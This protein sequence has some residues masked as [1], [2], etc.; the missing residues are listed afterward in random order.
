MQEEVREMYLKVIAATIENARVE[1]TDNGTEEATLAHLA[2][3]KSRWTER[4][5]ATQDFTEDPLLVRGA[6]AAAAS[7]TR[8]R[9][10]ADGEPAKKRA[11]KEED[12]EENPDG[13]DLKSDLGS[14]SDESDGSDPDVDN[15]VL[16]QHERVRKGDKWKVWLKE[17]IAHINGRD[18]LFNKATCDLHW[19]EGRS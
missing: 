14:S 4:L 17:G 18:Y 3:L 2:T 6:Q 1:F 15:Y 8:P 12:E 16:A 10:G 11:R 9:R 13:D 7:T 5:L 19:P